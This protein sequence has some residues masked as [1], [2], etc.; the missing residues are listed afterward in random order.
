MSFINFM[1]K[2]IG[3]C[4]FETSRKKDGV[5]GR[6]LELLQYVVICL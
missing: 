1:K 6:N 5:Y 3:F 2:S 4:I